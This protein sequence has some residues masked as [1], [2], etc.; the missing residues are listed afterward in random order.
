MLNMRKNNK[1]FSQVNYYFALNSNQYVIII[2]E[3]RKN[4]AQ[5]LISKYF[6]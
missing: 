4:I 5:I 2:F 6:N 1:R 3:A